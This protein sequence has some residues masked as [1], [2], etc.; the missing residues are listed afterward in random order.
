MKN[1]KHLKKISAALVCLLAAV[2][3]GGSV[4][5]AEGELPVEAVTS[6]PLKK[7]LVL[8]ADA[9]VPGVTFEFTL[10][11]GTAQEGSATAHSVLAGPAGA[12][13]G[14]SD[15]VSVSGNSAFVSFSPSDAV[16]DEIDAPSGA[17]IAFATSD[18]SDEAYA[19]K[20]LSI[21][22]SGVTFTN[23]GIYRYIVTEQTVTY[24]GIVADSIPTR[25]VDVYVFKEEDSD[26]FFPGAVI[27]RT[28]DAPL[29]ADGNSDA[30]VK[31]TGFTNWLVPHSLTFSKS[32]SGNQSST[33]QYFRFTVSLTGND[34]AGF[35]ATRVYV[36]GS[37]DPAPSENM[38]TAYDASVMRAANDTTLY[39]DGSSRYVTVEQLKAGKDFY[40]RNG[41]SIV[42]SGI[43]EG[44]GYTVTEAHE[45][46][47]TASAQVTG[48]V[49]TS[50]ASGT[51]T[52]ESLEG[53]AA[54]AFHNVRNG[55][56]PTTGIPAE[57]GLPALVMLA[58]IA[59]GAVLVVR[60]RRNKDEET[61]RQ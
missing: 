45:E 32:V 27:V 58:A 1:L 44:M 7:Y 39:T 24:S 20:T 34:V 47:Y 35:D 25:Y 53:N 54:V 14:S 38:A 51:V 55:V 48:D 40:L 26:V 37:Y 3:F 33:N 42:L 61:D 2:T 36:T 46:G 12:V 60:R 4:A 9:S 49:C 18:T 16:T 30:S 17:S 59:G 5:S 31:S 23:T 56:L 6:V 21:D 50:N 13:F 57:L 8:P 41:Q 15:D 43:P 10:T 22:L 28:S 52:D 19:E 29:D 11:P